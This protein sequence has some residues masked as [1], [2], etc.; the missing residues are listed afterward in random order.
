MTDTIENKT[1]NQLNNYLLLNGKSLKDFPNMPLPSE[2]PTDRNTQDL[3]QLIREER[4]YDITQL[5]TELHQNLPL[6]NKDQRAIYDAV[7]EAIE[8]TSRYFFVDGP[9]GTGKTFLY[10]TLFANVRSRGEIALAVASFGIAA[11]L[12]TG[13]RT[14]HSRFKILIKLSPSSTCNIS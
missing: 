14:A 5:Q 11:L 2:T 13:G 12:I 3:D 4:S 6:L 7:I 9:G 1:L 8:H 10:N